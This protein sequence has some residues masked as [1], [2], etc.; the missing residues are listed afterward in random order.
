MIRVN[1]PTLFRRFAITAAFAMT[2]I[3]PLAY[4]GGASADIAAADC[5]SSSI[6]NYV[7]QGVNLALGTT[8][9]YQGGSGDLNTSIAILAHNVVN[10]FSIIVGIMAVLM[11]MYGGLRYIISGGDSRR[12]GLAKNTLIYAIVGLVIVALAQLIVHYVLS[13]ANSVSTNS[14][15]LMTFIR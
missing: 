12:V 3:L 15:G 6:A 7:E 11:I 13:T 10:I 5:N 2:V 4:S 8:G 14:V 1:M 9:C